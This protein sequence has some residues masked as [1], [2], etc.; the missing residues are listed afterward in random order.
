M[1]LIWNALLWNWATILKHPVFKDN[2]NEV[3]HKY[4][5]ERG[6]KELREGREGSSAFWLGTR[7]GQSVRALKADSGSDS[8][9]YK[10]WDFRRLLNFPIH[11][12]I[13]EMGAILLTSFWVVT[14]I[15]LVKTCKL[16]WKIPLSV[17]L[18]LKEVT[19]RVLRKLLGTVCTEY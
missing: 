6:N 9:T 17:L 5:S 3:W 10:S 18:E 12:S 7:W 4:H 14:K 8:A 16:L 19:Y 13:C 1:D 11:F 15:K 2:Y